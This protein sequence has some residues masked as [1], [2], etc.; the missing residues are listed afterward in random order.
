MTTGWG[1][2]RALM[3]AED[4]HY[5]RWLLHAHLCTR[6]R[7]DDGKGCARGRVLHGRWRSAQARLRSDTRGS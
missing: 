5:R 2:R 6:C 3:E 1:T 7:Q 4:M